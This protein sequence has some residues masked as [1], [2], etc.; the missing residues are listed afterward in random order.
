MHR[1]LQSWIATIATEA[2]GLCTYRKKKI[3]GE[4]AKM[5][6]DCKTMY[7]ILQA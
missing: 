6:L 4:Q 5:G 7:P 2:E 1:E 3:I